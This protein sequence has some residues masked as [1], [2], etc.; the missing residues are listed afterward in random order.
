MTEPDDS[1]NSRLPGQPSAEEGP[2]QRLRVARPRNAASG[3]IATA[4]RKPRWTVRLLGAFFALFFIVALAAV[5]MAGYVFYQY[6]RDLPEYAQLADYQPPVATRVYAGDGRLLAEY[7]TE[8]RVFRPIEAIP[9]RLIDAFISAEDKNFFSH[10]GIDVVGVTRAVVTNVKN[11]GTGR[12]LVGASTITQQVAK[13][14]LLGNEVSWERK[15]KEAILA[16]RIERAFDKKHILEL[17]LNE[18]YLGRGSYGVTAAALNYFNKSLDE[19]TLAEAAFLAALPKA[20]GNYDPDRHPDSAQQRRDWVIS[21]MLEDARISRSAAEAAWGTAIELR[22]RTEAEFVSAEYFAEEVRREIS[23]RYGEKA[24]YEGGLAIRS[25]L[26][27]KL[28]E[29]A[30]EELRGGLEVYDRRYG[31]R[32]PIARLNLKG[33]EG[34]NWQEELLRVPLPAG[35]GA[36]RLAAVLSVDGQEA[37]IGFVNGSRGRIPL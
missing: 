29:I 28:Q 27:P 31:W 37:K 24:L 20:P 2:T 18:I 33:N 19:L 11:I 23:A 4:T 7:A 34:E 30:E 36:R 8:R 10:S 21:R 32:G 13:N 1:R 26:D 5:G 16:L 25:T 6:G 3:T 14:F 35:T 9:T 15:I 17:Y 22:Q 12:R